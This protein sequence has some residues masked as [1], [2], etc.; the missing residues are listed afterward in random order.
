MDQ[1]TE[2]NYIRRVLSGETHLFSYFLTN[3]SQQVFSLVMRIV[4]SAEDAEE[5]TQDVFLKAFKK[6]D[7][8][9]GDCKF[10]TW[11]FRI[12]YN[13]AISFVRKKKIVFPAI[14]DEI[15]NT[16]ADEDVDALLGSSPTEELL[17]IMGKCIEKLNAEE[18]TLLTLYYFENK[19]IVELSEMFEITTDNVKVKLHRIRKKL[20]VMILN[21]QQNES[22]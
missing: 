18:K 3:Y 20:Y 4:S 10:S 9:R 1:Q 12:A 7:T 17:A 6:L 14:D 13:T 5:L 11:L 2:I 16:V 21:V 8:Y 15:L 19:P 22:R